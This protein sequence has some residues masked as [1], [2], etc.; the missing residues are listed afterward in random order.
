MTT[1]D[2]AAELAK[3]EAATS[4]ATVVGACD[5]CGMGVIW[6]APDSKR[7]CIRHNVKTGAKCRG[8]II[9]IAPVPSHQYNAK[10]HWSTIR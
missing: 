10:K 9:D 8:S 6:I 1:I 7:K 3:C 4:E 5:T 2:P